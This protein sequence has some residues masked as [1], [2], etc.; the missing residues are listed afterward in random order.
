MS[1]ARRACPICQ[2]GDGSCDWCS[3]CKKS[4]DRAQRSDDGTVR[5]VAEWAARRAWREGRK[6]LGR[7]F[8]EASRRAFARAFARGYLRVARGGK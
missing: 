3:A 4:Y 2:G 1:V 7:E 5:A 6:D 8:A